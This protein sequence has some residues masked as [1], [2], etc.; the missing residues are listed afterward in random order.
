MKN[1]Y[2]K[3]FKY[4]IKVIGKDLRRW[5][6]FPCSWIGRIN[7]VKMAIL[8]KLIYRFNAISI[9]TP[10][11]FFIT[12]ERAICEFIW[13]SNKPMT[14]K[15]IIN[16]KRIPGEITIPDLKLYYRAILIKI[17]VYGIG[18]KRSRKINGIELKT[19]KWTLT[20][21]WSLDLWQRSLNH[22]VEKRQ[23]FKKWM[24]PFLSPSTKLK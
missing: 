20:Q 7:T 23:H 10:N 8:S 14:E 24:Y 11:Q 18:R 4:V 16:N 6:D 15:T 22:P 13:N 21:L 3:N 9:E 17:K 2:G 19:Q 1:L 5:K 12:L